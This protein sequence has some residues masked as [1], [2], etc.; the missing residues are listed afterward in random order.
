MIRHTAISV[1]ELNIYATENAFNGTY[2]LKTSALKVLPIILPKEVGLRDQHVQKSM[3]G[4]P[5]WGTLLQYGRAD[6]MRIFVSPSFGSL[7]GE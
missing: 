5:R 7:F 4:V 3:S 2:L 1:Q 6:V